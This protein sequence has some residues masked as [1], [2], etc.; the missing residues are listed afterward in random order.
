MTSRSRSRRPL[1]ALLHLAAAGWI[2]IPSL[3]RAQGPEAPPGQD[4]AA[5]ARQLSNPIADLVSIPL[6]F[7][8]AQGVGPDEDTRFIL[9]VQPVVPFS[10]GD[11]WNMIMRVIMPFIGQPPLVAGGSAATGLGDIL[12]SFFFSPKRGSVV[13]GVGPVFGLPTT[14]EPTLGLGKWVLGPTVVILKQSG[15]WTVGGLANQVWSVAG[16]KNRSEVS[17]LFLQPFVA[18]TSA[19]AVTVSVNS[20]TARNWKATSGN[21]WTIPVNFLVTKMATFGTFPASYGGGVGFYLESPDGGPE[22]Q[23]RGVMSIL[24]PKRR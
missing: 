14:A 5:L 24:M 13:W 6:Q 11:D 2:I 23:L 3:V 9:N 1:V 15:R 7:N 22:W 19:S 8:W 20:E 21:E 18:Y 12:A 16:N 10:V 4:A 17:Q